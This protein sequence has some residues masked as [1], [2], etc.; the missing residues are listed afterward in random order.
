[1]HA[2]KYLLTA[3]LAMAMNLNVHDMK[4]EPNIPEQYPINIINREIDVR[5]GSGTFYENISR[6]SVEKS[7]DELCRKADREDA[8]LYWNNTLMDIGVLEDSLSVVLNEINIMIFLE[9][10]KKH[11]TITIY[12][13]HPYKYVKN[14]FSPPSNID[15]W[16]HG[17][18]KHQYTTYKDKNIT[19]IQRMLNGSE[20]WEFDVQHKINMD[21]GVIEE[22]HELKKERL[23]DIVRQI[24]YY[25]YNQKPDSSNILKKCTYNIFG[26][27][28]N[29][30][31]EYI[32]AVAESGVI[33]KYTPSNEL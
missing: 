12:H 28:R 9:K 15:I 31:N 16:S 3:S 24:E 18:K 21:I 32:Q 22:R 1:M 7:L 26:Y 25:R 27:D 23:K 5:T 10:A 19:I 13:I 20:M 8:W 11:D 30:I 6:S 17:A 4:V 29:I 14:D 2:G 33:L